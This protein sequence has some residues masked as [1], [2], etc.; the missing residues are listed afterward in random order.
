MVPA[1]CRLVA[2][3]ELAESV[4][5]RLLLV[6]VLLFVGGGALGAWGYTR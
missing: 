2:R 5:S 4:R 6:M 1:R 3:F